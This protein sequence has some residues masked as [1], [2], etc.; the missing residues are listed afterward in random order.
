MSDI[1][2][3]QR[4]LVHQERV[5]SLKV[6]FVDEAL[7]P[8]AL[9]HSMKQLADQLGVKNFP[10]A[11]GDSE[12]TLSWV[13]ESIDFEWKHDPSMIFVSYGQEGVFLDGTPCAKPA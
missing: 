3:R 12:F 5:E 8:Q 1:F 13:H 7:I 11:S 6:T 2:S 4:G 9:K 10:S